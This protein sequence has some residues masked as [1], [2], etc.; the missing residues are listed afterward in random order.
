MKTKLQKSVLLLVAICLINL[1][2]ITAN[3]QEVD[4]WETKA[5]MNQAR[6][7]FS[8]QVINGKIYVFGGIDISTNNYLNSVEEYDPL[9]NT[10]TIKAPM[11]EQRS[12]FRTEIINGKIYAIGGY[13]IKNG[14][15]NSLNSV[16][17]YDPATNKWTIKATMNYTRYRFQSIV[18]NNKIYVFGGISNFKYTNTVEEYDPETNTWTLK[19]PM[20]QNTSDMQ[21]ALLGNNIFILGGTNGSA[22]NTVEAFDPASNKWVSKAAMH[23]CRS[24]FISKVINNK[25]YVAG[26]GQPETE[27]YDP[28]TDTWALKG[29]MSSGASCSEAQLLNNKMYVFGGSSGNDN[30]NIMQEFNPNTGSWTTKSPM[31][32]N[33]NFFQSA[34]V[35]GN[36]YAIGGYQAP[37]LSSMEVYK[38]AVSPVALSIDAVDKATVNNEI[39]VDVVIHNAKSIYA[40]DIKISYDTNL[41]E[42]ISSVNADGMKVFK[43]NVVSP[44]LNRYITASLGKDNGANG[45]KIILKLKFKAK[46]A[47]LAKVDIVKGRIADN[48]SL[49]M[50]VE[51]QN[52]GEKSILIEEVKDVNRNGEFTLLDLAIDASYYG[53]A[54]SATDTTKH[55]ADVVANGTIDDSDLAEV[56][57]AMLQNENYPA[58]K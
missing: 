33:R 8:S 50:D 43:E 18:F 37:C 11:N 53:M 34:V 57:E 38:P 2:P 35:D 26:G 49:E 14:E 20:S 29:S 44:G 12:N 55:D 23:F 28:V 3:A 25:I 24:L 27:E 19:S 1:F 9:T 46:K 51:E 42:Y 5:S 22:L 56:V 31:Q 41:L 30:L 39:T 40:E 52:C 47:G 15:N 21:T 36:I 13:V 10:W 54:A 32:N 58:N 6:G 7:S 17:E 48:V 4:T 45:D 16:E